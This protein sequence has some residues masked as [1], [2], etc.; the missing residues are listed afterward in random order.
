MLSLE[1]YFKIRDEKLSWEKS[2]KVGSLD[3]VK[4]VAGG[5]KIQVRTQACLCHVQDVYYICSNNLNTKNNRTLS[6]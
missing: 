3:N 2:S 1:S 4:H 5:G 6:I